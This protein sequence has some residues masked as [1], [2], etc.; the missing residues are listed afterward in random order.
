LSRPHR[1]DFHGAIHLVY[2]RGKAGFK[3]YFDAGA[4]Q[5][6]ANIDKSGANSV[7]FDASVLRRASLERQSVPRLLRFLAL[8]GVCCS[9]SQTQLFGYCIEPNDAGLV[10]RTL[11][12]PLEAFM[13]RLSGRYSRY[14]HSEKV[15]PTRVAAFATRYES[16]VVAPEYLPHAV[17]RVHARPLRTGL[18]RRAIDY[19][20][21]SAAAYVGERAPVHLETDGVWRALGHK[22]FFGLRGYREFMEKAETPYVAKLFEGGSLLDPRVVGGSV[23][24]AQ[25]KDAAAHRLAPLTRERLIEGVVQLLGTESDVFF[26]KGHQAVLAR[27]LVAWHALHSGSASVREVGRWFG[28]SAATLGH[29]IRHHRLVSPALFEKT[30]PGIKPEDPEREE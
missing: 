9:E 8:L 17:R 4:L 3:I 7:K 22:G 20:F 18:A 1:L 2:I 13:Q 19:P 29:A 14:L 10:L 21:S 23:F 27:A 5:C 25:A 15:L 30:L 6:E 24:V 11:G 12:T 28:V 16:K 26:K